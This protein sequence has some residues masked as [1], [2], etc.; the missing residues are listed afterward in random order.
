MQQRGN[1]IVWGCAAA[2]AL[3]ATSAA[4]A[5]W[6]QFSHTDTV[7][8]HVRSAQATFEAR[9]DDLAIVLSN[10]SPGPTPSPNHVLQG[11]LFE[12]NTSLEVLEAISANV[13]ADS[14]VINVDSHDGDVGD[15]WLYTSF[16]ENAYGTASVGIG[17]FNPNNDTINDTDS[18]GGG[19]FGM[20]WGLVS[21][22]GVED[23]AQL[24][25]D[26]S[27]NADPRPFIQHEIEVILSGLGD[28]APPLDLSL[29]NR[30][31]Q[32]V[33][34]LYGTSGEYHR[35]DHIVPMPTSSAV[36]LT[37]M[38][39]MGLSFFVSRTRNRALQRGLEPA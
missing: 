24:S 18:T 37:L 4:H 35:Y 26:A 17:I 23:H 27:G 15:H 13:A 19:G 36:G 8:G 33:R 20:D 12:S 38:A 29:A 25:E 30:D 31:I 9:G 11:V 6:L 39:V 3:A 22:A 10:I 28:V 1:H 32:D 16:D 34:F 14:F 7:D 5:S 2:I 21:Q